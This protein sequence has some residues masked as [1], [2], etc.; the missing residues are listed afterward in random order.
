[1]SRAAASNSREELKDEIDSPDFNIQRY[2]GEYKGRARIQRLMFV[3]DR[4][5]S[6]RK[7]AVKLLMKSANTKG[8]NAIKDNTLYREI[9]KYG[10]LYLEDCPE[11]DVKYMQQNTEFI[12]KRRIKLEDEIQKWRN[13]NQRINSRRAYMK[14]ADFLSRLG[15]FD[16]AIHKLMDAKD[17]AEVAS[18]FIE[19]HME[20]IKTSVK[21]GSLNHVHNEA[22]RMFVSY[23]K[24]LTPTNRSQINACMGL[25][26]MKNGKFNLA[27]DHFLRATKIS[28][29]SEILSKRDIG[30][31]G[32]LC[33][34]GDLKRDQLKK[35]LLDNH[36]FMHYLEKAPTVKK[37][38]LAMT[39][40]QYSKVMKLLGELKQQFYVDYYLHSVADELMNAVRGK[41]LVQYFEP[42]S[43]MNLIR[44]AKDFGVGLSDI[45][46]ELHKAILSGQVKGKVDLANHTLLEY[47][48]VTDRYTI[49]QEIVEEGEIF[50][51]EAAVV[52]TNLALTANKME[53][54]KRKLG[55][56][57]EGGLGDMN[58]NKYRKFL[59]FI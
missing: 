44:M 21:Q 22:N 47:R 10:K 42:F 7:S 52:M 36:P 38:V 6:A 33:A 58:N 23:E 40:S 11:A 34:L 55:D 17:F 1:M 54:S 14:I 59:N 39:N 49:L 8:D 9:F 29:F 4:C 41:A 53:L 12:N 5:P 28:N 26:Y 15:D 48:D 45:E 50:C 2:I 24:D 25:Y 51:R 13:L 32:A 31:Y 35:K 19:C 56:D 16:L 3:A 20:I 37:L 46:E 18:E 43:S 30:I 57:S 27:C